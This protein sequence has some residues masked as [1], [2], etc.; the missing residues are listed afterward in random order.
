[1]PLK[2]TGLALKCDGGHNFDRAAQGYVHLLPPNKMHAKLPGDSR[3]MVA[4]RHRFLEAG[5]YQLFRD[6]ICS[7]ISD[8]LSGSISPLLID[9]GCG[10]GYYTDAVR[11]ALETVCPSPIVCG[12]D[13]S[14]LA[15]KTAAIRSRKLHLAV[16]SCFEIPIQDACAD[17]LLSVF[18]PIVPTEFARVL[19]P[20]G[21]M[22][23]A[24][25]GERHLL[26]LKQLLYETPYLNTY[27]E[28]PYFGFTFE[29]RLPVRTHA[30][31]ADNGLITDLFAMTPYYWKTP[32]EGSRRLQQA[33][34]LETELG[35]D[36]LIYRRQE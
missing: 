33:T 20:G 14:K 3:E 28:T 32:I 26:G 4:A 27:Q 7:L 10:E 1:M 24:V 35:F 31:L 5:F 16:A 22:I 15:V 21:I 17:A 30:V 34:R 25:A 8:E 2:D 11:L 18:S 23:L 6:R 9:A 19:K 12:F 29:N 13:I 36:L